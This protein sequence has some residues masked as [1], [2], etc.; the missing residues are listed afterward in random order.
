MGHLFSS[1]IVSLPNQLNMVGTYKRVS[2]TG[3]EELLM[4]LTGFADKRAESAGSA[5]TPC[6]LIVDVEE[7]T[8][9]WTMTYKRTNMVQTIIFRMPAHAKSPEDVIKV[10]NVPNKSTP[11]PRM[12]VARNNTGDNLVFSDKKIKKGT[13]RISRK[14]SD[15]WREMTQVMTVRGEDVSCKEVFRRVDE[16]EKV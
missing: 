5:D 3:L 9:T 15:D 4:L 8:M 13:I 14:F 6:Y 7:I 2:C 1:P 16:M 11:Q 10:M 12:E